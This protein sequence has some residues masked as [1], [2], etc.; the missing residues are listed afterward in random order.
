MYMGVSHRISLLLA[1]FLS[2]VPVHATPIP[3]DPA[4]CNTKYGTPGG[5]Y[6]CTDPFFNSGCHYRTMSDCI[7]F[8]GELENIRSIG[9][10]PGGV[11]KLYLTN[12]D[13]GGSKW[14]YTGKLV[15]L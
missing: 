10:D 1:L 15:I 8:Q 7:G 14:D 9:P 2:L 4:T 12:G 6:F 3:F 13:C 11:C 5:V